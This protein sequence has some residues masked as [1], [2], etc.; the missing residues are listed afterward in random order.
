MFPMSQCQRQPPHNEVAPARRGRGR[1][2]TPFV[3]GLLFV[4][5]AMGFFAA[6]TVHRVVLGPY[7]TRIYPNVYVLGVNLGGLTPSEASERLAQ[8]LSDYDAGALTLSDG[9]RTWAVPWSEAG[10]R[11]DVDTTAQ[12]A[13]GVGR[14][15]Q[16]LENL[17]SILNMREGRYE[18]A[19]VFAV[20]PGRARGVLEQLAPEVAVPPTDATLRLEGDQLVAVPGQ[21]G[22]ALDVDAT[23]D[24]IVAT[25]THLGPDNQ[26]AL[27][28]QAVPPRLADTKPAQAQAEEMLN[29]QVQVSTYDWLTGETFAWT[30]EREAV[31]TWLRVEQAEDGSG[32][33]IRVVEEAVQATLAGLAA[34]MGEGRGFRLEEATRQVLNVFEAG[35]GAVELRLTHPSRAYVVQPGDDLTTIA[36]RFGMPPGL[37]AEA[38][39]EID[40]DWLHVGQELTIPSEDVLRPHVPVPGKQIVISIAE[41]RMR[42]YENGELL[43]D[44][45]VSTG[46]ASSPTYTG[47]FQVLDKNENAYAS[48]WD[49]WM[50]HFVAVYRAGGD[51]YNGIHGLPILSNGRRLWE[52]ALGSPASYG[53]IILG[54]Q[55][56]EAL[57]R[58]AEIGVLVTIE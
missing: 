3:A 14:A 47:E 44:W 51:T 13:F 25:V 37:I 46:V 24:N 30:L 20:D 1:L 7:E 34:E 45:P 58:W 48:Q 29:R 43:Y 16:G 15:D 23:L 52:G 17:L 22:R 53:C 28:F 6:W 19:P 8:A 39:P 18:V 4:L 11:L 5:G 31:V 9:E 54:I 2:I 38:N 40:L 26:F 36:T 32:P 10:L 35:G 55:E 50:P 41:Q 42:V 21:P 33:T 49:L 12:V 56:A 57:Y 27:T